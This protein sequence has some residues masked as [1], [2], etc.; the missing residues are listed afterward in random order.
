MPPQTR[1]VF[2]ESSG[3]NWTEQVTLTGA[4]VDRSDD[5]AQLL[6]D[7]AER[8]ATVGAE[9]GADEMTATIVRFLPDQTRLYGPGTFSGSVLTAVEAE[10]FALREGQLYVLCDHGTIRWA[11]V[12]EDLVIDHTSRARFRTALA[13]GASILTLPAPGNDLARMTLVWDLEGTHAAVG[14]SAA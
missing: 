2:S 12:S 1:T 3:T 14:R 6:N 7:F 4:A 13:A 5:A 11:G 10:G 9:L 8:A